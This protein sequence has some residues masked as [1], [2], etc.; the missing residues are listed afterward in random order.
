[1]GGKHTLTPTEKNA[2]V[3]R[4]SNVGLRRG[5]GG[6]LASMGNEGV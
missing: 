6:N 3:R 1:M 5:F 2:D 4:E